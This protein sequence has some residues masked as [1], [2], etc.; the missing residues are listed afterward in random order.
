MTMTLYTK[1]HNKDCF[2]STNHWM[3]DIKEVASVNQNP[4]GDI[5][6]I[7]R[8]LVI[9]SLVGGSRT[10]FAIFTVSRVLL[11]TKTRCDT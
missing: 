7:H 5:L 1:L 8:E 2:K 3:L 10:L 11:L 6:D 9:V 4:E